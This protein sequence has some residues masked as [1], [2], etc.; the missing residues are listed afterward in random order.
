MSAEQVYVF[1]AGSL[2]DTIV[3]LP[4]WQVIS[5]RHPGRPLH[6][7]TPS[8][9]IPGIP[10]TADV[11]RLTGLLG[12]V[13]RYDSSSAGL[14]RTAAAVR[15]VGRGIVYCLM[16]ERPTIRHLR[17]AVFM[18]LMLGLKIRGLMPAIQLNRRLH[19]ERAVEVAMPEWQRLLACAGGNS[20][21]LSLPLLEPTPEAGDTVARALEPI[22]N[23]PFLVACPGSK[24]PAKR[25]PKERYQA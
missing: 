1:R 12:E 13:I 24:M 20:A 5:Q 15:Q 19:A 11:Y 16:A 23:A 10:D 6:L 25:W 9:R 4:A 8:Q 17:D 21:S 18:R 3:S 22:R 7:I 2:G 14:V